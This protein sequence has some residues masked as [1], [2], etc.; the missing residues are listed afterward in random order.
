MKLIN[1]YIVKGIACLMAGFLGACSNNGTDELETLVDRVEISRATVVEADIKDLSAGGLDAALET[2][3]GAEKKHGVTKLKLSGSFN[4]QDLMTLRRL[5]SLEDLDMANVTIVADNEN[6]EANRYEFQ[7][8]FWGETQNVREYLSN[9]TIGSYMFAGF[10]SLKKVVLPNSVTHINFGAM[11][12]CTSL[13]SVTLPAKLEYITGSYVFCDTQLEMIT[14]PSSL[15]EV[16]DYFIAGTNNKLKAIFWESNAKVPTCNDGVE[17]V[18]L[19]V[20]NSDVIVSGSW[21]NVII[22]GVAESIDIKAKER[23]Q[24]DYSAFVAPRAFTAKKM[25]YTRYFDLGTGFGYSSGWET[26]VLPFVPISFTHETKG[27]IAPFNSGIA[28]AKAFWLRSLTSNGFVDVT[29]MEANVPYIIS[30]PNN[31]SYFEEYRLN[32][33]V[34]FTGENVTISESVSQP[35]AVQGP[36]FSLQPT[37]EPVK[38]SNSIYSLNV[39]DGGGYN[40]GSAFMRGG[41]D[42]R[43][44]EAYAVVGGRSIRSLIDVDCSSSN[45]TRS[46]QKNTTGIPQIGDM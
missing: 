20:S 41:G 12:T 3:L 11:H 42:V 29:S 23:W 27:V 25:T 16:S 33:W 19:Y 8:Y 45:T 13:E 6:G 9:N 26:I 31:D 17:N 39:R 28:D 32:G 37:Y 1:R 40:N 2:T 24:D 4:A 21:K 30:M 34:T 38:Q 18:F 10:T 36:E 15:K 43:A 35:T 14:V 5:N 22:N 7:T 46:N 44:F